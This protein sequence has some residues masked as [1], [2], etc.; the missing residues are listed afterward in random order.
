[1]N[2]FSEQVDILLGKYQ[3][4]SKKIRHVDKSIEKC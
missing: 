3:R 2:D 1:M 4:N